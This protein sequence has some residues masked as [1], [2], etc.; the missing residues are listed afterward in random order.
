MTIVKLCWHKFT[1]SAHT[2]HSE[3]EWDFCAG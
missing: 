3:L 1:Q 2:E